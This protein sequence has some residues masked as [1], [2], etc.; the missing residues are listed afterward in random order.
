MLRKVWRC[1]GVG[2][3]ADWEL[4]DGDPL[5]ECQDPA[6][7]PR[8]TEANTSHPVP[9]SFPGTSSLPWFSPTSFLVCHPDFRHP[10]I[11]P[12]LCNQLA[13]PFK[14]YTTVWCRMYDAKKLH[15]IVWYPFISGE[16]LRRAFQVHQCIYFPPFSASVLCS[17]WESW[18]SSDSLTF[19]FIPCWMGE[20]SV[21]SADLNVPPSC[22]W[23]G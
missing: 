6:A 1:K 13:P 19:H 14:W 18:L 7:V 10:D 11:S 21:P 5:T 4:L 9:P 23:C 15:F 12:P 8:A 3:W 20:N 16:S 22:W 2:G 17:G